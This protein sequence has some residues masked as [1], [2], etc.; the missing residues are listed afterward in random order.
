MENNRDNY[1]PAMGFG[2]DYK[3]L[4]MGAC[5]L[6]AVLGGSWYS[7]FYNGIQQSIDECKARH[8]RTSATVDEI[9]AIIVENRWTNTQQSREIEEIKRHVREHDEHFA[10]RRK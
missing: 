8:E 10:E 7:I 9:R 4:F 2:A 1:D 6:I 3:T 5:A